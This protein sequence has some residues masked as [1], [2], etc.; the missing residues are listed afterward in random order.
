MAPFS[1][2]SLV[3]V[4]MSVA[5]ATAQTLSN[6][7][8]P[9]EYFGG[10]DNDVYLDWADGVS[11]YTSSVFLPSNADPNLGAAVHWSIEGDSIFLAVAARATGWL[12][13]GLSEN[14]GMKGADVI[15]FTAKNPDELVDSYIL[16]ER[17][18]ITDDFQNWSLL[19]SH[20]EGGF[21]IFEAT[22]LLD[23]GDPQDRVIMNDAL[24]TIPSSRII[25]AWGDTPAVGYH[26][27]N[28][29]RGAVRW[30]DGRD[31]QDLFQ[32]TMQTAADGS[33]EVR[34]SDYPI[35]PRSTEYARF[36]ASKE[37]I[38][39]QGVPDVE[40]LNIVGF[41]PIVDDDSRAFIHHFAVTGSTRTNNGQSQNC[42][43][44]DAFELAY[45]WAPGEGPLAL[46]DDLGVPFGGL[47]GF[48]SFMMEIH[49]NNPDRVEGMV[50][51]SGVR[52][53]YTTQ[54]REF[55]MG[56]LQLGDPYIRLLGA[57]VG[58]G[59]SSHS[60]SCSSG[61][62]LE[63]LQGQSVTVIREHLHMHQSGT[64]IVNEQIR[65]GEVI[66]AGALDFSIIVSRA[67]HLSSRSPFKSYLVTASTPF[68]TIVGR[69]ARSSV[70]PLVMKCAL[71]SSSTFL[72]SLCS[73]TPPGRAAM[74]VD[75]DLAILNGQSGL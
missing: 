62:S 34:A 35:K 69:T 2:S 22:R 16:E 43:F 24:M 41:E 23:T 7:N 42:T 70:C 58:N 57:P 4:C 3:L 10:S 56:I 32:Q 67:T 68:A 47:Y 65:G 66:R 71:L 51:S 13:F 15:L 36:C 75:L 31:G 45:V 28:R 29:A 33:F 14:G 19:D 54:P 52:F 27:N 8:I 38:L 37:D 53:Y 60:F 26:G 39:A 48:N 18:P 6:S 11:R 25:A 30:F 17:S 50:D 72:E 49:Y 44:E 9:A 73:M 40:T 55:E 5:A 64:R 12:G 20:T 21:L 46:P 74:T 1:F 59:L 63:A 61:C